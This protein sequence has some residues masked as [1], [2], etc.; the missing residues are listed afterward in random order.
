MFFLFSLQIEIDFE[1]M[2][3]KKDGLVEKSGKFISAMMTVIP[4]YYLKT[5]SAK[6]KFKTLKQRAESMTESKN[7]LF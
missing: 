5:V 2:Y 4:K 6:E 3:G 7:A 1:H